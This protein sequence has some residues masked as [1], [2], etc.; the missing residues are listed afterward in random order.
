MVAKADPDGEAADDNAAFLSAAGAAGDGRRWADIEAASQR[1]EVVESVVIA[2]GLPVELLGLFGQQRGGTRPASGH[3]PDEKSAI[4]FV[5]MLRRA[6]ERRHTK[7]ATA[8]VAAMA[9]EAA[10]AADALALEAAAAAADAEAAAAAAA[11]VEVKATADG[12]AA[13]AAEAA[14]RELVGLDSEMAA[15]AARG[16]Q[17]AGWLYKQSPKSYDTF[18]RRWFVYQ[19]P[20]EAAT[21]NGGGGGGTLCYW[22]DMQHAAGGGGKRISLGK[23][24]PNSTR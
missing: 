5:S 14:G 9:M 19:P 8:A 20:D 22:K 13:E 11:A 4:A 1:W 23:I 12:E 7:A 3:A 15:E 21:S 24:V 18:F 2:L 16:G 17:L 10:A 6:L